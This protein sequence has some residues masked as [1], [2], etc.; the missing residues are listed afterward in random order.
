MAIESIGPIKKTSIPG[1]AEPADIQEA[2]RLYHYGTKTAPA[3]QDGVAS[4]SVAG[5]LSAIDTEINTLKTKGLGSVYQSS[6]PTSMDNGF[7]WVKSDSAAISFAN[8]MTSAVWAP[9]APSSNPSAGMLWIDSDS[10][11]LTMKVYDGDSWES[12]TSAGT[13]FTLPAS[14]Q[15]TLVGEDIGSA[16]TGTAFAYMDGSTPTPFSVNVTVTT[17][18]K[19]EVTVN[20]G[21]GTTLGSATG[22]ISLVRVV[23]GNL[24]GATPIASY[25]FS[26]NTGLSFTYIDDH[27]EAATSVITYGLLNM[28]S[29][30]VTFSGSYVAQISAKEIA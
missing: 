8:T 15:L 4:E 30:D 24:A 25:Y 14:S 20:L 12:V 19:N 3:N 1:L 2:L 6:K 11:P 22:A 26:N 5:Y 13:T 10:S 16:S 29:G 17:Y 27:S 7:V 9:T 23:N 21:L 28:T 18:S